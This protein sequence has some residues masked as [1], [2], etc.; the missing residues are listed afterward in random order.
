M[1]LTFL[2]LV[3]KAQKEPILD[4]K[5]NHQDLPEILKSW[6]SIN[7]WDPWMELTLKTW[8]VEWTWKIWK[9]LK[10][11]DS[12]LTKAQYRSLREERNQITQIFARKDIN[13]LPL[14]LLVI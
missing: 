13:K 5:R 8:L 1:A 14:L 11:E 7:Q 12:I 4:W 3:L 6:D 2:F 9:D 10:Q